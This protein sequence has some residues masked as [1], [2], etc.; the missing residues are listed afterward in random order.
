MK[1]RNAVSLDTLEY[2]RNVG[3]TMFMVPE[4]PKALMTEFTKPSKKKVT[5]RSPNLLVQK[6]GK[7]INNEAFE[8]LEQISV[9]K[10]VIDNRAVDNLEQI[11]AECMQMLNIREACS[12]ST[13]ASILATNFRDSCQISTGLFF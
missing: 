2:L 7:F 10:D 9:Q 12:S 8:N 13:E 4:D 6:G 3:K 5:F 11:T 1:R